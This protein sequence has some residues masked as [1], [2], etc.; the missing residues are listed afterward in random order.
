M[1]PPPW[2]SSAICESAPLSEPGRPA[3][4]A[5]LAICVALITAIWLVVLP[6]IA[7]L[8]AVRTMIDRHEAHGVDP[9]AK[10]YSELPAMPMISRRVDEIRRAE[11]AA[12]GLG[13]P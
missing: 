5:R 2:P 1:P 3:P 12:F 10:F 8:S 11:P 13:K 9:S 6:V 4:G 7:R